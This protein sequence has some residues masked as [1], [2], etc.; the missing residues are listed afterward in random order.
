MLTGP[1]SPAPQNAPPVK[2]ET[3][4]PLKP[5]NSMFHRF[6]VSN[7]R[8]CTGW[9]IEEIDK[10]AGRNNFSYHAQIVSKK[11]RAH[12]GEHAHEKL[13]QISILPSQSDAMN[14]TPGRPLA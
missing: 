5:V 4:M 14:Y 3:T 9:I 6:R 1:A 2:N 12:G 11:D 13:L 7:I 10:R 8:L